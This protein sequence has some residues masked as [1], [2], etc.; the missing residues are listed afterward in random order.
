[1]ESYRVIPT[2]H[3][4][5]IF[6]VSGLTL[7]TKEALEALKAPKAL[8][9]GLVAIL[10]ITP[11]LGFVML[12]I[13]FSE[14]AFSTG[15][16]IFCTV[17]TTL[18]SG[19]ALVTLVCAFR[20]CHAVFHLFDSDGGDRGRKPI[21]QFFDPLNRNTYVTD[22]PGGDGIPGAIFN[23]LLGYAGSDLDTIDMRH[24]LQNQVMLAT[25]TDG[26]NW[27]RFRGAGPGGSVASPE[28]P[29]T[30]LFDFSA[31]NANG[32]LRH[33]FQGEVGS[34]FHWDIYRAYGSGFPAAL[35]RDDY[36]ELF[37]TDD[38]LETPPVPVVPQRMFRIPLD[39]I[40]NPQAYLD[41][42]P[43][44]ELVYYGQDV[45]WSPLLQRYFY[46]NFVDDANNP[47]RWSPQVQW[48]GTGG[49]TF[50][51][52][53]FSERLPTF[54]TSPRGGG[55]G[56]LA[57][58]PLGHTLDF[59]D[60]A[61]PNSAFHLYYGAS[62]PEN[63]ED[64]HSQDFD[65]VLV[66]GFHDEFRVD[67]VVT[68][69]GVEV[70]DGDTV[71]FGRVV[72]GQPK[73]FQLVFDQRGSPSTSSFLGSVVT[74]S[75]DFYDNVNDNVAG[76][77]GRQFDLTYEASELGVATGSTTVRLR[78]SGVL[79]PYEITLNLV[80]FAKPQAIPGDVN[81]DDVVD[82]SDLNLFVGNLDIEAVGEA[83]PLDVTCDGTVTIDDVNETLDHIVTSNGETGTILGDFNC[84]GA[85]DV[86][87]DAFI[88]VGNLGSTNALYTDGDATFDGVVDVLGDAFILVGN[89]GMSNQ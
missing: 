58:T 77:A 47:N 78:L 3:L 76:S 36:L 50:S 10:G 12:R 88:L 85:V 23:E 81:L 71:D 26:V 6:I 9:Y 29:Y 7:N 67:G 48:S 73:T 11:L 55:Q 42:G 51:F 28:E 27:T 74:T 43:T 69:N 83:V 80:G 13:P 46:T 1:M 39:Q 20:L 14:E 30:N 32:Q 2:I 86:L 19:V 62:N 87:G 4:C 41:A 61:S 25:S 18:S 64:V 53:S 66:F 38:S 63:V 31:T 68:I 33:E 21:Y 60:A 75:G 49:A 65:H 56:G 79:L 40:D 84:D 70:N 89:L 44:R 35:V 16:A 24:A 54:D 82:C 15:L 8:I 34:Q 59:P 57:G 52:F 72:L 17:P 5:T 22:N 45:K 37:F